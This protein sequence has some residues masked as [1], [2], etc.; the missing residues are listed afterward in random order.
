M[1]NWTP[2]QERAIHAEGCSLL[3]SAAAGAG[4]TAV[5]TQRVARKLLDRENGCNPEELLVVT[6]TNAAATEMRIRIYEKI[7][8]AAAEH[9][10]DAFYTSLRARLENARICTIDSFCI[11]LVREHFHEAGMSPDFRLLDEGECKLLQKQTVFSVIEEMH[12]KK[13]AA[14]A[15]LCALFEQ[16]RDDEQLADCI[17]RLHEYCI[18]YPFADVWLDSVLAYYNQDDPMQNE[19]GKTLIACLCD[20]LEYCV[21]LYE[22]CLEDITG[23]ADLEAKLDAFLRNEKQ[24]FERILKAAR[25]SWDAV[26][27]ALFEFHP[28]RFPTVTKPA[29]P[30]C[31]N[32]VKARRDYCKNELEKLRAL[33]PATV[34]EHKE[35]LAVLAPAVG[36]LIQAVRLFSQRLRENKDTLNAYEF[37]DVTVAA[38]G[39]LVKIEDG[40]VVRTPLAHELSASFKEILVDEYQDTNEAQDMLFRALSAKEE[41]LFM[42][43]D[44][45]Q[46]IYKFRL[47]MPELFLHKSETYPHYQA[48]SRT[49]SKIILGWNFRSRKGVVDAVNFV[50][51]HIMTKQAGE[52]EYTKDEELVFSAAYEENEAPDT[53]WHLLETNGA[54]R[55]DALRAEARYAGE[56]I[57]QFLREQTPVRTKNGTRAAQ[58]GDFC[59]LLRTIKGTGDIY[60]EELEKLGIPVFCEKSGDFFEN[61]EI[62]TVLSLLRIID[63]PYLDIETAAVLY[64]PLYG[65]TS[66]EIA[67]LRV[68]DPYA[69]LYVCL[70]TAASD[71]DAKAARFMDDFAVLR[72]AASG[73]GVS[74]LLREIYDR[75]GYRSVVCA[76][77]GGELRARNLLVLSEYA[78]S[79]D[80]NNGSGLYGFLRYLDAL[81]EN[82]QK[83]SGASSVPSG[84]RF[85]RIM[86]IHKSKGLE[87]PFVFLADTAKPFNRQDSKKG[88]L[89]SHKLGVG[90]KRQ[91]R[92]TLRRFDTV[93]YAAVRQSLTASANA[94]EMRLLYVAMT[95]A[96]EHLVMLTSVNKCE[97]KLAQ[98]ACFLTNEKQ[99]SVYRM[100]QANCFADWLVPALLVHPSARALRDFYVA[101]DAAIS[102]MLICCPTE[103]QHAQI[104]EN[105]QMPQEANEQLVE[106]IAQRA[107]HVY[108][109]AQLDGVPVKR[110]ASD[111]YAEKFNSDYFASSRPAFLCSDALTPAERGT[112]VHKFLQF[113]SFAPDAPDVRTQG[114]QLCRNGKLTEREMQALDYD[115]IQAFLCSD[116]A[117]RA[118]NAQ[119][120]YR[121]M[122]FTLAVPAGEFDATLDSRTSSETTVVIGKIDM[123]FEENGKAVIVDYKTDRVKDAALLVQRYAVQLQMYARATKE[124]LS[125]PVEE[126]VLFSI[127]TGESVRVVLDV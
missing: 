80:E 46:S 47:A 63:N 93:G 12:A 62:R 64:S 102:P 52:I 103:E 106:Q 28:D 10:G 43:G 91:D 50:F 77:S 75:T 7:A 25:T 20:G 107:D 60:A 55:E 125:L 90:I 88:M 2:E 48:G 33:I 6:F 4:K 3:I 115:K 123:V 79:F 69:P 97:E 105:E 53:E 110:T 82:G 81:H 59:I 15:E 13:D 29:N 41:N 30:E 112:A 104:A 42:V 100:A 108:A 127:H 39:L 74:A 89:I 85:V 113:C 58:F 109:F 111:L 84:G 78:A 57:Q 23:E 18:A 101:Q 86:S 122:Q 121:E 87:F 22:R 71:G 35:D 21:S 16:G 124:L 120:L 31:K 8:A 117:V 34:Q 38:L 70:Q 36:S 68:R 66:D 72:D 118:R 56:R 51:S 96:A 73:F 17:L 14:F 114:E 99:P 76:M 19:W 94:E 116:I 98:A 44:V 24:G 126:A 27:D 67:V 95:R 40:T 49:A 9:P 37:G 26:S 61:T 65:F 119:N 32:I 5:L 45:K 1:M 83:L 54:S 11:R 92:E